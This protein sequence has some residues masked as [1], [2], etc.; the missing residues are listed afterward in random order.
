MGDYE[1]LAEVARGG[2]GI[3]YRAR[4][5]SLDRV[6]ALKMIL[7]GSLASEGDLTRFRTEAQ[8]AGLLDHP[9]ILPIHEVGEHDGQH[10]FSMKFV[11][12]G[13]MSDHIPTLIDA[14][15]QAVELLARVARAVHYAHQRG[16]LHRDLKPANILIDEQGQPYVTDFGLARRVERDAGLT[17]SGAILGTPAYMPPEQAAAKKGLSTAADVYSLG[18]ILYQCLTGK[19]PFTGDTPL[20]TLLQVLEREPIR[21]RSIRPRVDRDLETIC[22]KCLEKD[23]ARRYESAA[24]LAD[25]L[26]R[27]LRREP[28]AARP[29]GSAGRL[30]RWCRRNPGMAIAGTVVVLALLTATV[31][32]T[33]AAVRVTRAKEEQAQAL[34]RAEGLRLSAISE[35]VRPQNPG[36]AL[37]LAIEGGERAPGEHSDKALRAVLEECWERRAL[38]GHAQGIDGAIYRPDGKEILSWS[39]D[40][41]TCL[42]DPL[43]GELRRSIQVQ[44][45]KVKL[46]AP[47][48]TWE[49][50][51][52]YGNAIM[53]AAWTTAG[54]RLIGIGGKGFL[55]WN[56]EGKIISEIDHPREDGPIGNLYPYSSPFAQFSPDGSKVVIVYGKMAPP[57]EFV[58]D[59]ATGKRLFAIAGH[60][61]YISHACFSPDSRRLVSCSGDKTVR[62]WDTATGKVLTTFS[63]H[64]AAVRFAAFSPDGKRV[65]SLSGP[66]RSDGN[67][68]ARIWAADS[69]RELARL[70]G[71]KGGQVV[72]G[73]A[74][75]SPDGRIIMTNDVWQQGGNSGP[76]FVTEL[77]LWDAATGKRLHSLAERETFFKMARVAAFSPDG[78]LVAAGGVDGVIRL[79][80]VATG[81]LE[82]TCRGH[83]KGMQDGIRTIAFSPD[84]QT[85]L[86]G[87]EDHTL[88]LWEVAAGEEAKARRGLWTRVQGVVPSPDGRRLLVTQQLTQH[89]AQLWDV[90]TAKQRVLGGH[91]QFVTVG[92]FSTDGT[93]AV[94]ASDRDVHVWDVQTGR[95]IRRFHHPESNYI[96]MVAFT[97][98]GQAVF[99]VSRGPVARLW[100]IVTGKERV[101][102]EG[103]IK[104]TGVQ[105]VSFS[106]DGKRLLTMNRR[107]FPPLLGGMDCPPRLW[108]AVTGKLI[109]TLVDD[110]NLGKTAFAVL[111]LDGSRVLSCPSSGPSRLWD[112]VTGKHLLDLGDDKG[113]GWGAFHPNGKQ[114]A[115]SGSDVRLWD[116]ETGKLSCVLKGDEPGLGY[117]HY[118]PDGRL[119]V[120]AGRSGVRVWETAT[121]K[122]LRVIQ[123]PPT[124]TC[125]AVFLGD[126]ERVLV[127]YEDPSTFLK[128]GENLRVRQG[129]VRVWPV[130]PLAEA[131]RRAPRELTPPER[132]RYEVDGAAQR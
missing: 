42:W 51:D 28:I 114:V 54:L 21:P 12:G 17:Q 24:A 79:W 89:E 9:H 102:L 67:V 132:Q 40:N 124:E 100:D 95:E 117:V 128:A 57:Q 65:V 109:A 115:T 80:E 85:L 69:G 122:Q 49:E 2:M 75:F 50:I 119:L 26:E 91:G 45:K 13:N 3:V 36:L 62:L 8:A 55:V 15:R 11:A 131:K 37:L 110:K 82:Q 56:D 60:R 72:V 81:K 105:D 111:S 77:C 46:Q 41:T 4:Q 6:V 78:R 10:F 20:D 92:R 43:T 101:R 34:R 59:T 103:P 126:S 30:W 112:G 5:L 118:S 113:A 87:G 99:T 25:D 27:W 98:D 19:P 38:I 32:S 71:D 97:P 66:N 73:S 68:A 116:V 35:T 18:A 108:D 44:R 23:S 90:E 88:R 14:P 123:V 74:A 16:V 1:L 29:L 63:E 121:G 22:L 93:R 76:G 94:T 70:E 47:D 127:Y 64:K 125:F 48:K 61:E 96:D 53:T 52:P 7:S 58:F 84:G 86:S 104:V 83:E 129:V 120:T 39:S 33:V 130:D 106:P 107:R 31:V